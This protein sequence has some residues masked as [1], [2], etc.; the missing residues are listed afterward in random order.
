M[1]AASDKAPAVVIK[2]L[3]SMNSSFVSEQLGCYA[4]RA[5]LGVVN[6]ENYFLES[7]LQRSMDLLI[8]C[9]RP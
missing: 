3:R 4:S 2:P 7:S 6:G 9:N 5:V 8:L 1:A